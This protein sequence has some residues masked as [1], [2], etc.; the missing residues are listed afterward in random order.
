MPLTIPLPEDPFNIIIQSML[1]S[2]KW[3]FPQVPQLKACM[4]HSSLPYIRYMLHPSHSFQFDHT[5][6]IGE[7]YRSLSSLLCS[8]L[9]NHYLVPLRPKYSPQHPILPSAYIPPSMWATKFHDHTK[10]QTKL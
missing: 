3:T 6:T 8:F 4:P 5:N 2:S 9:H 1:G 10:Q 7:E